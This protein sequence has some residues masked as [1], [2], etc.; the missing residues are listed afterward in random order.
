MEQL[1]PLVSRLHR[2]LAWTGE[3]GLELPAIAVVGAQSVGKSSVL[4][5]LV[6]RPFLPKGTGIVTQRPLILQVCELGGAKQ[7]VQLMYDADAVEHGEFAHKRG[8][9]F[10]DFN[11]IMA[12]IKS[13]TERLLGN[14]KNVSPVPIFLKIVSPRVVDL[15]LIDLPGITKVPVGDQTHD[16]E[17]Q[18]REMIM[19]RISSPSCII[20]A[21][22][23]ANTDIATSD[24]L[25]MA[26]EVDPHG[27]RT[28]GVITK[29]DMVEDGF[30][31]VDVLQGRVYKLRRG[32]VGVVCKDKSAAPDATHS[33]A[34]EDAFFT[35]HP[36]YGPI[37]KRCGIRHLSLML[38]E[39][40]T[41]HIKQM[42]PC[43][44]SKLLA[45]MHEREMELL[46]YGFGSSDLSASPGGCLLHFFTAFSQT[47]RDIIHGKRSSRQHSTQLFG[48]ARINYIFNDSYLKT[49]KAF[50]PLSGL[51]DIEIRTA[52]RNS[53]GPAS[54][55]FVP[56]IA[57]E[58]LV[59]KQIRLLET[60]SLQCVDQVYEELLNI[61]ESCEIP[62]LNRFMNMRM[63]MLVVIKELL[64]QCVEPTKDM[65][66]NLI[67]I[68]LAYINTNHPDFLKG[69]AMEKACN[70]QSKQQSAGRRSNASTSSGYSSYSSNQYDYHGDR[71]DDRLGVA[72]RES[73]KDSSAK[74]VD[75]AGDEEP[76]PLW[77]PNIP[78]AVSL[79]T[80]PSEREVIE[81]ELIKTLIESY[82]SIVRKN[83]ADAVPKCIMH[84][85]VN[86]TTDSIQQ[87]L[88]SHLYKQELYEEL[89]AE[90]KHII[91][92]REQCLESLKSLRQCVADLNE[93]LDFRIE[94]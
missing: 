70:A 11:K 6:G 85:M 29:C 55:L 66:R 40:L 35:N 23:A 21:L 17:H 15:T 83:I 72:S 74:H 47:F 32:Y 46:S 53:T 44:K 56:E 43:I 79:G 26:R 78:K 59:K 67:K 51:S 69:N 19:E 38:N 31:A 2:I 8:V 30:N 13:E 20:L 5:A 18:I 16:I 49:L 80:E 93:L 14:T 60:P 41:F 63:R 10:E 88:I 87:E 3:S 89:T 28:I 45:V 12:E 52:I 65:I 33:T 92:R 82:F 37:A 22:T 25:Q 90:S 86:K 4:E 76:R 36:I 48:G 42:F 54:A 34:E 58:N 62:E 68:E 94:S 75:N 50:S 39:M 9:I 7:N 84:F 71:Y 27:L 24:S 57:F 73:K 81:A 61:L 1:I 64:R 91:Q 77:L